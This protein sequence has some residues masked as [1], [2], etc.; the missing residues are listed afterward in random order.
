MGEA[1]GIAWT[2]HTWNPWIGCQRVSEG[3]RNCYAATLS[4]RWGKP[5]RWTTDQRD[6]TSDAYWKQPLRWDRNALALGEPARVFCA[7]M[8]DVFEDHPTAEY[9]RPHVWDLVSKTP[10]LIWQFL[11]KRPE[12][13][14]AMLDPML[15]GAPNVWIGTTIEDMRVAHRADRLRE[16]PTICRFISYEPALGPLH[17]IN[18][19][20]ISWVICGGE[21][22]PGFR[23]ME[24]DWARAMRDRCRAEGIAY[25]F[26]Q[27]AGLRSGSGPYLDGQL[28]QEFPR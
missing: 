17:E 21:S 5:E 19:D 3:C 16:V 28:I 4:A 25:F 7:S 22:G 9:L 13:I 26:K 1:T 11:T 23:H 14:L 15:Q 2:D 18:L 24:H 6:P 12:N 20:G 27:S 10:N 8:C